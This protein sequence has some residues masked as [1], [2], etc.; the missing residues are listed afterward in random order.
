MCIRDSYIWQAPSKDT[1][2]SIFEV[3]FD[4][5]E[6]VCIFVGDPEALIKKYSQTKLE[7]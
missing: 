2:I 6:D 4:D 7:Q 1:F 3:S 5:T